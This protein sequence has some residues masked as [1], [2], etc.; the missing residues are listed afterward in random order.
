M[1]LT[2]FDNLWSSF[3]SRIAAATFEKLIFFLMYDI[4]VHIHYLHTR[5]DNCQ[6]LMY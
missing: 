1:I 3:A 2:C 6:S 5:F 4:Y